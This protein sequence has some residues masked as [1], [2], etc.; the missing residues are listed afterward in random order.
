MFNFDRISYFSNSY[1]VD[2]KRKFE[3]EYVLGK[4]KR[5]NRLIMMSVCQAAVLVR[6]SNRL[7]ELIE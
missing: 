4:F 2:R 3:F 7:R 1:I 6:D 5:D